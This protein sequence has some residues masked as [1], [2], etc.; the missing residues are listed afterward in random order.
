[1]IIIFI[2][3]LMGT[4]KGIKKM[5]LTWEVPIRLWII[6]QIVFYL[7]WELTAKVFIVKLS[8]P[9][10]LLKGFKYKEGNNNHS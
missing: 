3:S 9:L 2:A 1:M 4:S 6:V 7:G 5:G 8:F 10:L